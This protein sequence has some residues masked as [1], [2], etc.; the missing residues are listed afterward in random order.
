MSRHLVQK[1][2]KRSK[3]ISFSS[4]FI[5][6]LFSLSPLLFSSPIFSSLFLTFLLSSSLLRYSILLFYLLLLS[7]LSSTFFFFPFLSS[8]FFS[9]PLFPPLFSSFISFPSS[10]M[11]RSDLGG[12]SALLQQEERR[13]ESISVKCKDIESNTLPEFLSLIDEI[14]S[15]RNGEMSVFLFFINIQIYFILFYFILHFSILF[16]TVSYSILYSSI[17]FYF[18]HSVYLCSLLLFSILSFT[19]K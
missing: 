11:H 6:F 5:Y 7:P 17:L 2:T 9:S 15:L 12:L 19:N 8:I 18:I 16:N 3:K 4:I 10:A 13:V 1:I 14:N